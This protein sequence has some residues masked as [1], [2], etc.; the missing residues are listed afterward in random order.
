MDHFNP[1]YVPPKIEELLAQLGR[2]AEAIRLSE[3]LWL[4]KD[5][6]RTYGAVNADA[7]P[8]AEVELEHEHGK[9]ANMRGWGN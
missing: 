6:D 5:A 7:T 4:I 3:T 8:V 9:E 1:D 2:S